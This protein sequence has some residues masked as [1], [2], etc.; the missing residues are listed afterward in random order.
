MAVGKACADRGVTLVAGDAKGVDD[1]A[2]AAALRAGGSVVAVLAEGI[3]KWRP[4]ASY[5]EWIDSDSSNFA[6]VSQFGDSD[7]WQVFRAMT[8][9]KTV[10]ALSAVLFV[11]EAR[12]KGGTYE[13]GLAALRMKHPVC[14]LGDSEDNLSDGGRDLVRRGAQFLSPDQILSIV[15]NVMGGSMIA[16]GQQGSLA[17]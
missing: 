6:A 2:E 8:R 13:A 14:V 15:T 3:E 7:R 12:L 5:R 16:A 1:A 17:L 10:I 11:V 4:R 9:N